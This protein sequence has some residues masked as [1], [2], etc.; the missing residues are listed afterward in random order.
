MNILI[1][2]DSF[3]E[4]LPAKDVCAAIAHG[5]Q[6]SYP[7]AT[8]R[9][10]PLADG[11]EGS[12]DVISEGGVRIECQTVDPLGR[13]ILAYYL[14][15]QNT[16]YIE[17]ALASGLELLKDGEKNPD[18]TSTY[19]TGI[20]IGDAIKKGYKNIVLFVGGSA[21]ND[22]GMGM[23]EALG[24]VFVDKKEQKLI[25]KGENLIHV[26]RIIS[27]KK[28]FENINFTVATDVQNSFCGP[29]GA[30]Y[31][32]ARQKG[33]N[34]SQIENLDKGLLNFSEI[35][36][37]EKGKDISKIAGAGAAG[38]LGGGAIAF[39]GAKIK[40]G[41][42]VI[43]EA[44]SLEKEIRKADIII[45]GEGKID[46]QTQNGKLVE[47]IF[48]IA[49]NK[50]VIVLVGGIFAPDYLL[51]KPNLLYAS[52]IANMP[53]SLEESKAQAENLLIEK[54]KF[55]GKLLQHVAI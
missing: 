54:G 33:A 37:N 45:T 50:K 27:P 9:N 3:K 22:G 48:E 17:M 18:L 39:L 28:T 29:I 40:K 34:S 16:A 42:E 44:I 46:G 1:A 10:L 25:S 23:A 55:I 41:T 30:A 13:K 52:A 53:M 38:G 19:G 51:S 21:T 36:K 8:I 32:Y 12:L 35:I 15:K 49:K 7:S 5:I 4:S 2:T 11:G 24:Y 43:F 31:I 47:Q 26:S 14:T 6:S 20:L